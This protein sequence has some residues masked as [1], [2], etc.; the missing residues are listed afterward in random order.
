MQHVEELVGQPDAALHAPQAGP[1]EQAQLLDRGGLPA[2]GL[3]E[4]RRVR[5]E[6]LG[7]GVRVARVVLGRGRGQPVPAALGLL[8]VEHVDPVAA[9]EDLL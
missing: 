6:R 3:V 1:V 5:P 7:D 2:Q 8:R 9:R 4:P